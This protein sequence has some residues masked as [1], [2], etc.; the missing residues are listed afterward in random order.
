MLARILDPVCPATGTKPWCSD[1]R[2]HWP[3]KT[4]AAGATATAPPARI[5]QRHAMTLFL[6]SVF[7]IPSIVVQDSRAAA[8]GARARHAR[9]AILQSARDLSPERH[10]PGLTRRASTLSVLSPLCGDAILELHSA[11]TMSAHSCTGNEPMMASL[12]IREEIA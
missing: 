2:P 5:T 12:A 8:I 4:D 1:V 3:Q 7:M 11:P 10:A 6:G 9:T